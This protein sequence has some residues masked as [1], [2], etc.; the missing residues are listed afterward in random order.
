MDQKRGAVKYLSKRAAAILLLLGVVVVVTLVMTGIISRKPN[1]VAVVIAEIKARH[2]PWELADFPMPKTKPED[3]AISLYRRAWERLKENAEEVQLVEDLELNPTPY[4]MTAEKLTKIDAILLREAEALKDLHAGTT[5]SGVDWGLPLLTATNDWWVEL[6][7]GKIVQ[8]VKLSRAAA[9]R[10]HQRGEERAAIS[11]LRDI[12]GFSQ[13]IRKIP[14]L[15]PALVAT[16]SETPVNTLIQKMA[17]ELNFNGS[18]LSRQEILALIS[19]LQ[20]ERDLLSAY[21]WPFWGERF[22]YYH[23]LQRDHPSALATP[24]IRRTVAHMLAYMG[25]LAEAQTYPAALHAATATA[26]YLP[27]SAADK[28]IAM[29]LMKTGSIMDTM[30]R[31]ELLFFRA[32]FDRRAAATVWAVKL[33]AADHQG[34]YPPDLAALVAGKYLSAIPADPFAEDAPLGY[35]VNSKQPRLYSVGEDG[36]DDHGSMEMPNE[37]DTFRRLTAKDLICFFDRPASR[38]GPGKR[39]PLG[40]GDKTTQGAN[41][42]SIMLMPGFSFG[43]AGGSRLGK[44]VWLEFHPF[45]APKVSMDFMADQPTD[46]KSNE[47]FIG[48]H[49]KTISPAESAVDVMVLTF[50]IDGVPHDLGWE[51]G[52]KQKFQL[53]GLLARQIAGSKITTFSLGGPEYPLTVEEKRLFG[54]LVEKITGVQSGGTV[55]K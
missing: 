51:D 40:S 18:Q 27:E 2:E 46:Q 36:I 7:W 15:L 3:N 54:E 24:G 35:I 17:L 12:L 42:S 26:S 39:P 30:E 6:P 22:I 43:G 16:A 8:L 13:A 19:Q 1:P 45:N 9:I 49:I 47:G 55:G 10:A 25:N 32:L 4:P 52:I 31:A 37:P 21:Q 41:K 44:T 23:R 14:L 5:R 11:H 33:Y 34:K 53:P 38:I 20:D 28:Q 50:T 29:T 48:C